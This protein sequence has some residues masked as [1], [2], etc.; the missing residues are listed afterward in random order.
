MMPTMAKEQNILR[1]LN[2]KLFTK[3]QIR[4]NIH[5]FHIKVNYIRNT[6]YQFLLASL[7]YAITH[8]QHHYLSLDDFILRLVK[9]CILGTHKTGRSGN[10]KSHQPM[11]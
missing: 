4:E 9:I 5:P 1:R 2:F 3:D 11:G 8:G 10:C 7:S 6:K